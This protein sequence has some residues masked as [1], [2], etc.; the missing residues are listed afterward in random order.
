MR[1]WAVDK[2]IVLL[3][4]ASGSS[5]GSVE[6]KPQFLR[7]GNELTSGQNESKTSP[8]VSRRVEK[9]GENETGDKDE[10]NEYRP[11]DTTTVDESRQADDSLDENTQDA[12]RRH[13]DPPDERNALGD[14]IFPIQGSSNIFADREAPPAME[15]EAAS[16]LKGTIET[17]GRRL[18]DNLIQRNVPN[19][20]ICYAAPSSL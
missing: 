5:F 8:L 16:E 20:V 9:N 18:C 3:V 7:K 14:S 13:T 11:E 1:F 17:V 4:L 6:T 19:S 15:G 2:A 10:L 12:L